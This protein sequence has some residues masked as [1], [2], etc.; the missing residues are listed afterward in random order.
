[1]IRRI[2]REPS[3]GVCLSGSGRFVCGGD[4][5]MLSLAPGDVGTGLEPY[6]CF[7]GS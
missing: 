4:G 5:G 6:W 1:M 7:T 2:K 3:L